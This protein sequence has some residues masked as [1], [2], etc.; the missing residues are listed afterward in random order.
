MSTLQRHADRFPITYED[1][2]LNHARFAEKLSNF[3]SAKNASASFT[4][5]LDFLNTYQY[6]MASTGLLTGLG[7][8]T[9]FQAGAGFWNRYGRTL[10]N[11]SVA[12]LSYN[13]SF[14]NGTV[15]P[16]ITLRTTSQARIQN[17]QINWALGFFGTTYQ[18][19]VNPTFEDA[20]SAFE[21]VIIPEGGT[22][23]NTLASYDSC[24]QADDETIGYLGELDIFTYIPKYL[25]AATARLNNYA[26]AGFE[27]TTNDTYAMQS[28]CAYENGYIGMS[29]FC[30]LFTADEWAGFENTLDIGCK[31]FTINPSPSHLPTFRFK[32]R[33]KN[34]TQISTATATATQPGAPK[35]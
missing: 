16:P 10:Y 19:T 29:D 5:P 32:N 34:K 3:T 2:G 35:E 21:V 27:L 13:A 7:A 31:S 23:N 9:E 30:K 11:A 22:E 20:T 24:S 12:Q 26:P 28:I 33:T 6:T 17:S 15:R 25:G 1:D 18:S 14:P 8:A 4:G